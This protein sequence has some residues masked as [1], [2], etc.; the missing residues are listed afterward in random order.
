MDYTYKQVLQKKSVALI[1][2]LTFIT[3]GIYAGIW[4]LKRAGEFANLGTQKKLSKV[5]AIIFLVLICLSAAA[6]LYMSYYFS[7][8]SLELA[9]IVQ[10]GMTDFQ[11]PQTALNLAYAMDIL[12]LLMFIFYIIM[13]FTTRAVINEIRERKKTD[14]KVNGFFTFI[15]NILYLQYEINRTIDG[16]EYQKRVGPWLW[17]IILLLVPIAIGI[18]WVIVSSI[19]LA[20][21]PG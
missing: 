5:L 2:L 1:F 12:G 6:S 16:R 8:V 14:R 3:G 20:G 18:I 19:L 15:F 21:V 9:N 7:S 13:A 11:I 4:Y 17:L 10:R